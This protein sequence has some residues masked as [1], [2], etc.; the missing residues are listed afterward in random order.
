M[1]ESPQRLDLALVAR[2]LVKSRAK[3]QSLIADGRV[4]IDGGVTTKANRKVTAETEITVDQPE[5]DWVGRGA[6]K[7]LAALDYFRIGAEGKIAAD[8]GASTGGFTQVLLERGAKR[9]YAVD[10]GHGQL[11]PLIT[12][13]ARVINLE[14]TN[15][16]DLTR[17]HIPDP[18]DL[19]VADVS[20]ISLAKALPAALA[21][22][23][24]P[25]YLIALVKPQFE[26]GKGN[27][28]K[29]GIVRDEAL[30]RRVPMDLESWINACP[31]WTSLGTTESPILGSDGNLEFL[32]GAC[33]DR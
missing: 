7:L 33:H 15:A 9:V 12:E 32:I 31:G 18:L 29:G 5:T 30:A 26:V 16:R 23:A 28:G 13:D 11:D 4:Y 22:A 14:K 2:D 1:T 24:S 17:D 27:V 19:I 10:V 6:Q 25:A 3:A 8:I 20:F 21:L